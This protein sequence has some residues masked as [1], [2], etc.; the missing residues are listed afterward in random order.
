MDDDEAGT[1]ERMKIPTSHSN[2]QVEKCQLRL[3]FF[4]HSFHVYM[5]IHFMVKGRSAQTSKY[6][7]FRAAAF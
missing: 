6:S 3:R 5:H 7:T 2:S 1:S 4:P